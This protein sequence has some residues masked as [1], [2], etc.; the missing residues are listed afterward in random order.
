[1][2]TTDSDYLRAIGKS[3]FHAQV[4]RQ[5]HGLTTALKFKSRNPF[6][7]HRRRNKLKGMTRNMRMLI[8]NRVHELKNRKPEH[9]R[10]QEYINS[11]KKFLTNVKMTENPTSIPMAKKPR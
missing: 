10:Y 9:T 4:Q 3:K 2:V 7:I 8:S 5:F 11:A 1:M 6:F